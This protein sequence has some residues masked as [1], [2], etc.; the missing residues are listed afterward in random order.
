MGASTGQFGT[1]RAQLHLRQVCVYTNLLPMNK[2]EVLIGGAKDKFD[3]RGQL[4]DQATRTFLR[5]FLD[6][7]LVWTRQH[8][9]RRPGT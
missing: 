4:T 9:S 7:L 3:D 6:S 1:A 5:T 8:M 2:P